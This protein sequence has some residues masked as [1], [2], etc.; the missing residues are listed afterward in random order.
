MSSISAMLTL[1][2][3]LSGTKIIWRD[4]P[5]TPQLLLMSPEVIEVNREAIDFYKSRR[6]SA[7]EP[8]NEAWV[9]YEGNIYVV[10]YLAQGHFDARVALEDLKYEWAIAKVLSAVGVMALKAGLSNKF[11]L[12]LALLLPYSEWEAR[13]KFERGVRK[14][15]SEF[16]FCDQKFWVNVNLFSCVPEG[17]G[18]ALSRGQKIGSAFS[19]KKIASMMFGYRDVSVVLFDKGVISGKTERLGMTKMLQFVQSRTFDQTTRQREQRL[20]ET[21]HQLGKDIKP[22]NFLSLVLSKNSQNR[23]EE[24]AQISEAVK[25]ARAEYWKIISKFILNY[26]PFD[27]D[28]VI[29]GG[30]TFDYFRQELKQLISQNFPH[31]HLCLGGD[32]EEDVRISFNF[33]PEHRALCT[34]LT[35]SY[36]LS[37]FLKRQ[38]TPQATTL[39]GKKN[40]DK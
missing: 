31:A 32:L 13:E 24:A 20:L 9:E 27:I 28:E 36:A 6:I 21:I 4:S 8:E 1:D 12:A 2:P 35:D 38:V 16:C 5:L 40:R 11:D 29:I 15:L 30:G 33:Q 18:H 23:S 7:L 37:N 10:G 26:I 14:A 19:N 22:R 17:G 3:G 39:A 34:R 25:Y